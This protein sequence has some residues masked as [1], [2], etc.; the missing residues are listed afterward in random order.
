MEEPV[1]NPFAGH[2]DY[3]CFACC[4][5]NVNGLH[6]EFTL[7]EDRL[8][9]RWEPKPWLEG[10]TNVLHGGVQSTLMDEAA[11]WFIFTVLG[12]AGVTAGLSVRFLR[13][14]PT[15]AGAITL[16][17]T[18]QE[19]RE[20]RAV[21]QVELFDP[22]GELCSSGECEYVIYPPQIA[23]RRLRYPGRDAFKAN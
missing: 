11:S 3:N 22:A 7:E 9:C 15:N 5:D 1:R 18:I 4:P 13:P 21:I 14:V 23:E 8:L 6:M 16:E 10:Y 17:A 20:K 12:T 2:P 19:R